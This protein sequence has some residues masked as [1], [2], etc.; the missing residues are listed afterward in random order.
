MN[1]RILILANNSGGLYRFRKE[2][3]IELNQRGYEVIVITPF[4]NNIKDLEELGI[5]LIEIKID[6]RG[7]NLI[8]DLNLLL[9]YYK[10]IRKINPYLIISYTIKPNLYGG[11]IAR[12]LKKEYAINITGLGTTFQNEGILNK[13]IIQLYKFVCKKVKIV[14]F[15]NVENKN[16]FVSNKII[17]E[18]KCCVLNGAGVNLNDFSF[19][20]YPCTTQEIH[21]LF[22]GRI[23]REKGIDELL[24]AIKKLHKENNIIVL[25][26]IGNFEEDYKEEIERLEKRG[27][28]NYYG[29]QEDVRP[30]I[31]KSHCF[32]L[33]S[34]HEGMANTLLECAAM[35]RPLIT[36][37]IH[38]CLEAIN[39]NGYLCKVKNKRD[40]YEKMNQFINLDYE[41]KKKLGNNSRK[42]MERNFSKDV[43]VNK[44]IK[45]L[46]S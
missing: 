44:T 11:I 6:R 14:Y 8:K 2:L 20:Q 39:E 4:D 28:I 16:I 45:E 31:E 15:E 12:L 35:G 3:I 27:I 36:S 41:N 29:Y 46:L 33:P 9:K 26:I 5:K 7:M 18:N 37:D 32:V 43:V 1:N 22:I 10:Y 38:G 40:L 17:L 42:N 21:F 13:L 25:D 19:R 30:F 34:H 23:M 24:W